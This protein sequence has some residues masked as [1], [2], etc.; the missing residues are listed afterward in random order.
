MVVTVKFQ[1]V[2]ATETTTMKKIK[3]QSPA[4]AALFA[5]AT[6]LMA[7][8]PQTHAQST[9]DVL[10]NKLEQKG[11]LTV[12][13][14]REIRAEAAAEQTNLVN[15]ALMAT[16]LKMSDSIKNMQFYGVF[17]LRYEYRG[18]NNP[19]PGSLSMT[20]VGGS[21]FAIERFR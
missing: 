15:S 8:T 6:A 17:R 9:D 20:G 19:T 7:L 18:V 5:G 16:K 14:A 1:S 13:E 21:T 4:R 10:I 2:A 3:R 11:I 12:D